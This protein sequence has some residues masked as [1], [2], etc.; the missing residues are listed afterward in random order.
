MPK[1]KQRIIILITLTILSIILFMVA[2]LFKYKDLIFNNTGNITNA[3]INITRRR[4][5]QMIAIIVSSVL[6]SIASLSFQTITHN[7]ILTPSMLGFD[8]IFI[9]TQTLMVALLGTSN[10]FLSSDVFNFI[11]SSSLMII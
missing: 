3:L 6:V 5:I 8:A 1:N 2:G 10:I 11:I 7:R 9:I 4:F